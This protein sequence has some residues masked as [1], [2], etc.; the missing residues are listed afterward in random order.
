MTFRFRSRARARLAAASL[1]CLQWLCGAR[2]AWAYRPFD[3][4]DA[5]VAEPGEL[6]VEAGPSQFYR[7]GGH[8]YLVTPAGVLNLGF[9][10]D[11][12]A[13][14]DFSP[15]VA[16]ETV[17]GQR[18]VRLL[19]NDALVK[20]VLRHGVL[21][22]ERGISVAFEGGPLLPDVHGQNRFGAQARLIFSYAWPSFAVHFNEQADLGRSGNLALFSGVILEGPQRLMIRPVAE[23][24]VAKE[25]RAGAAYSALLGA[26]W[27]FSAAVTFDAGLR[28][29]REDDAGAVEARLGLTWISSLWS[30]PEAAK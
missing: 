17:P 28:L 8:S 24:F 30:T 5:S 23:L 10:R 22:G 15:F 9:A 21:Q 27:P 16:L 29:A 14:V 26:I 3:G 25:R 19:G 4:T 12:E 2:P 1:T 20:W 7:Y 11:F 13:I 18:R 6:E